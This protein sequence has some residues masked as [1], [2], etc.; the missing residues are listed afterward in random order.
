MTIPSAFPNPITEAI[1]ALYYWWSSQQIPYTLIGGV[2]V[3]LVAEPRVTK[4]IDAVVWLDAERWPEFVDSGTSYG[5]VP[6]I[7]DALDFARL[8]RVLL[9]EH[10]PGGVDI[11]VSFGSLPFEAEMIDGAIEREVVGIKIRVARPEDLVIDESRRTAAK[12]HARYYWYPQSLS[13]HR[14]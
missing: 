12:G 5:F 14:S 10:Q 11:D 9:L 7:P 3:S 4:D 1:G 6:R 2:A 13:R 8:H